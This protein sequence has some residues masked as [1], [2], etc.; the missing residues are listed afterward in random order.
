MES[1]EF[2]AR[3]ALS[4]APRWLYRFRELDKPTEL[5]DA[6]TLAYAADMAG[7]RETDRRAVTGPPRRWVEMAEDSPPLP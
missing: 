2:R 3:A 6:H 4:A 1:R 7:L 5:W